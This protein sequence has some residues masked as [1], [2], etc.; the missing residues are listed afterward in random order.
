MKKTPSAEIE[1]SDDPLVKEQQIIEK[2]RGLSF[3]GDN[4]KTFLQHVDL[5]FKSAVKECYGHFISLT[6]PIVS[7]ETIVKLVDMFKSRFQEQYWAIATLLKYSDH[8]KLAR[9]QHL[10]PFYDRM[11]FYH[12]LSLCR[13]RSHKTFSWWALVNA[14]M[15]YGSAVNS[16]ST[17]L[18]SVF[19][20]HSIVPNTVNSPEEVLPCF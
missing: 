7:Q 12:F 16:G 6:A 9:A 1:L 19:F 14:C 4:Y 10:L 13:V 11:I 18:D 5:V 8:M 17:G 2:Y 3:G 15:R 20:G